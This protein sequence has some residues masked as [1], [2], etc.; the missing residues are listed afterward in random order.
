MVFGAVI[1]YSFFAH[2][3]EQF[4]IP[5]RIC[6]NLDFVLIIE[7]IQNLGKI[8][9]DQNTNYDAEIAVQNIHEYIKYLMGNSQQKKAKSEAFDKLGESA[10]FRLQI[11]FKI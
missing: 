6:K 10:G 5:N 3:L 2:L 4:V 7:K 8:E 11:F 1:K 9:L